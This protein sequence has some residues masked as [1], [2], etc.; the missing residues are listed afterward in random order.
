MAQFFENPNTPDLPPPD[1]EVEDY[2]VAWK[3][4]FKEMLGDGW[5]AALLAKAPIFIAN[6][7]VAAF[8]LA[9][10][11]INIIMAAYGKLMHAAQNEKNAE[12]YLMLSAVIS[13]L[14]GIELTS[15]DLIHAAYDHGRVAA[16]EKAGASLFNTLTAE[17]T[18]P[19]DS[20]GETVDLF[21]SDGAPPNPFGQNLSKAAGAVAAQRFLG[22]LMAFSVRAG[23]AAVISEAASLTLIKNFREYGEELAQNLGLGRLAR[24]ALA[25]LMQ[26]LVAD[27]LTKSLN[28]KYRPKDLSEAQI[29]KAYMRGK[30][31]PDV[32]TQL[33]GRLGYS[34]KAIAE[35]IAEQVYVFPF[36]TIRHM[37]KWQELDR[38]GVM[39][40]LTL[41]GVTAADAGLLPVDWDHAEQ[42]AWVTK[43]ADQVIELGGAKWLDVDAY[44][45]LINDLP[46]LDSEK[47]WALKIIG[48]VRESKYTRLTKT[49]IESAFLKGVIDLDRYRAWLDEEHFSDDDKKV[50]EYL[51]LL[52]QQAEVDK[53]KAAADAAKA[54]ADAAA[55]KAADDAR[56]RAALGAGSSG[57]VLP[58]ADWEY[59]YVHGHITDAEFR[60]FLE[61]FGYAGKPLELEYQQTKDK[62]DAFVEQQKRAEE[63]GKNATGKTLDL[64]QVEQAY[65][66][67]ILAESDLVARLTTYGYSEADAL[68]LL[69]D[70]KLKKAAYDAQQ[71][72][73]AEAAAK[74]AKSKLTEN[75]V[76]DAYAGGLITGTD[77]VQ[78]LKDAGFSDA[79][80]TVLH[81]LADERKAAADAAAKAA[82]A[83]RNAAPKPKASL[84]EML[85]A[86]V[87]HIV[88]EQELLDYLKNSGY[89]AEDIDVILTDA[90]DKRE[91][92][93]R[94][95]SLDQSL[96]R[97]PESK[98]ATY[99]QAVKLYKADAITA[100]QFFGFLL[101]LGYAT[102]D[103]QLLLSLATSEKTG[104]APVRSA[105]EPGQAG[106]APGAGRPDVI[107]TQWLAGQLS[108]GQA[109]DAWRAEGLGRADVDT[110][111]AGLYILQS[112]TSS[113]QAQA[114]NPPVG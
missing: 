47:T 104:K 100:K 56:K 16:M 113:P 10:G 103:A 22:F 8:G 49:E 28:W 51:L 48:L 68:V 13:D 102:E 31:T 29:V 6:T 63:L 101:D 72:K 11:V 1:T 67:G 17:F 42:D 2:S 114:K 75:Q 107:L 24:R 62:R 83:K 25:P 50:L 32:M 112:R 7:V 86:Y 54:K 78:W 53:A 18:S 3:A 106:A 74:A 9:A 79:E 94:A 39:D 90:N 26:V 80:I 109:A 71:A 55:A 89:T 91:S 40:R 15:D 84:A 77:L 98:P 21:A 105:G 82:E 111:T 73:A 12:F 30:M 41:H 33:L 59:A 92:A 36:D 44:K 70:E 5:L 93:D 81:G 34:D 19:E 69:A 76:V 58:F 66:H 37:W 110:L 20:G 14:L 99:A 64:A 46:L 97:T 60:T 61:N 85:K 23:N 95:A 43:F 108:V 88:S 27:P 65:I 45:K 52:Q 35:L 4:L 87:A 96:G 57:E 38:Q